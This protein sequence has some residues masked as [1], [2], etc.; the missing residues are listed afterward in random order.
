MIVTELYHGQGLGNQ[1]WCY[2]VTRAIA[3]NHGYD[4]GIQNPYKFK[5]KNFMNLD[6]GLPVIGGSGPEGGPPISLPEGISNYYREKRV[7]H[8]LQKCDITPTDYEMLCILD[9]TKIDGAMQSEFYIGQYKKKI[10]D[11][12]KVSS[13]VT[14]YSSNNICII[15]FRGGDFNNP[16][17]LLSQSYYQNAMKIMRELHNDIEFLVVTDDIGIASRYFPGYKIVGSTAMGKIDSEKADHHIGGDAAIDYSII[18]NA[19][20]LILSNS[21]FG[22]WATWT[23]NVVKKVIAPMYWAWHN[24]SD[25]FWSQGNALTLGWEYLD[26][27]G[28]LRN[29]QECLDLKNIY[30]RSN[31]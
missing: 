20:Y 11:W 1:L 3:L 8:P 5:G 4:F 23:N 24:T 19:H 10:K 31:L 27:E 2:A 25:G 7:Y 9:G 21:S 6:F 14:D 12:F 22:W 15:H 26:R 17:V 29:Y 13:P 28:I 16:Y 18:N 30:E